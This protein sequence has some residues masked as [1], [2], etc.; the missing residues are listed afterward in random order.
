MRLFERGGLY[1]DVLPVRNHFSKVQRG[2]GTDVTVRS[3]TATAVAFG[4]SSVS[5]SAAT[6]TATSSSSSAASSESS[7]PAAS[8]SHA[9][10]HVPFG[11]G[12]RLPVLVYIL[13]GLL[14]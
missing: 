9:V 1:I 2:G 4:N 14:W 13:V 3:T 8:V 11:I 7:V 6:S 5:L 10:R 12:L